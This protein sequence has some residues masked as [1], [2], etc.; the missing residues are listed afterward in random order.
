LAQGS[1]PLVSCAPHRL[2][3][4]PWSSSKSSAWLSSN[5][6]T[7]SGDVHVFVVVVPRT[8]VVQMTEGN[9][10]SSV[11]AGVASNGGGRALEDAPAGHISWTKVKGSGDGTVF[12]FNWT[13]AEGQKLRFQT[14]TKASN[15]SDEEAARIARLC[16]VKFEAGFQKEEVLVYRQELY[17]HALPKEVKVDAS[18]KVEKRVSET[19]LEN[20]GKKE[21]REAKDE[22]DVKV[23]SSPGGEKRESEIKNEAKAD[24][25]KIGCQL[26]DVPLTNMSHAKVRY[27]NSGNA[28]R[29]VFESPSGEKIRFQTTLKVLNND[30]ELGMRICRWCYVKFEL[31]AAREEVILFRDILYR[32]ANQGFNASERPDF[33][34]P[35][36]TAVGA[37][38]PDSAKKKRKGGP[39]NGQTEEALAK[40]K[41]ETK[42]PNTQN[43]LEET[44]RERKKQKKGLEVIVDELRAAGRLKGAVSFEGRDESKKGATINGVYAKLADGFNGKFAYEKMASDR[45]RYILFSAK[46]KRWVV[47]D[48]LEDK[49]G[50][51]YAPA[52]DGAETPLGPYS[53]HVFDGSESGY[54]V[55]ESVRCR[56]IDGS[57]EASPRPPADARSRGETVANRPSPSSASGA[58]SSNESDSGSS[59]SSD[60]QDG[61]D[62]ESE[63]AARKVV[64]VRKVE[65]QSEAKKRQAARPKGRVCAKFMCR[66]G[67]RC[68]CHFMYVAECPNRAAVK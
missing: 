19:K 20:K 62:S 7:S 68:H 60:A 59:S 46:R 9:S 65:P 57:T 15:N 23:E 5:P 42:T 12:S 41:R 56:S 28:C 10:T 31:G 14:T 44:G 1:F 22:K 50:F 51:A 17:Q 2:G 11:P 16:Y 34:D 66:T 38:E 6:D 21:R 47:C 26:E 35:P 45:S 29:F 32:W 54:N 18:P 48:V 67:L 13:S 27:E 37:V 49:K 40:E 61:S 63:E 53:W 33:P 24:V 55:D 36:L 8:R 30:L 25:A 52:E 43:I 3:A 4:H 58:E 39:S 64:E